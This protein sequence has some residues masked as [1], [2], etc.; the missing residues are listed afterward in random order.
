MRRPLRAPVRPAMPQAIGATMDR[1]TSE[2]KFQAQMGTLTAADREGLLKR[3][4]QLCGV[5]LSEV[6]EA[7]R[8]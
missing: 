1:L 8:G 7:C 4:A 6:L 5:T 3:T 2:A